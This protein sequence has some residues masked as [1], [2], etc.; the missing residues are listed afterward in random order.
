MIYLSDCSF[1]LTPNEVV[2]Y[3]WISGTLNTSTDLVAMVNDILKSLFM[4]TNNFYS[5]RHEIMLKCWQ[6]DPDVRPA[7]SDLTKQLKDMENQHKV[8]RSTNDYLH[9]FHQAKG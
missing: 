9:V 4:G 6:N 3:R 1:R 7:F 2:V 5:A 8:S